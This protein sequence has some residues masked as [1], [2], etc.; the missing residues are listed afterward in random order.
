MKRQKQQAHRPWTPT[1]Q[2]EYTG[3]A[4]SAMAMPAQPVLQAF[5]AWLK[6]ERGVV[7]ILIMRPLGR[8][9]AM[10]AA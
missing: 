3:N 2:R 9:S 10:V 5:A 7:L 6:N 4:I 1:T 8:I